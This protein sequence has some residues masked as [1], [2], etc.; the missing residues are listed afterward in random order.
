LFQ[1]DFE[2]FSDTIATSLQR[3]SCLHSTKGDQ[4]PNIGTVSQCEE[5]CSA[6]DSTADSILGAATVK[7]NNQELS[8]LPA[9]FDEF[10]ANIRYGRMSSQKSTRGL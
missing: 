9:N 3:I 1:V 7:P 8:E 10:V 6:F 2:H 5:G 4:N